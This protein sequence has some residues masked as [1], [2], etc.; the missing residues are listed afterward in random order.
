M[1]TRVR[2]VGNLTASP[3]LQLSNTSA[4]EQQH[5]TRGSGAAICAGRA[6]WAYRALQARGASWACRNTSGV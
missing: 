6:C 2:C 5:L 4:S 1:P 3:A